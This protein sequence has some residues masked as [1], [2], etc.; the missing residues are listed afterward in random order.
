MSQWLTNL[1]SLHEDAVSIPGL[2]QCVKDLVLLWQWCR[3]AATAP[4]LPLAWEPPYA[5]GTALRKQKTKKKKKLQVDP[6]VPTVAQ[7]VKNPT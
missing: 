6:G 3:P 7:Q 4:I 5:T 2:A 1:T